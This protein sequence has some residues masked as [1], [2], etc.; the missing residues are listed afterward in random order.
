MK[1]LGMLGGLTPT[2]FLRDY[3]HKQPYLIRQAFPEFIPLFTR[4]ALFSMA[5]REDVESRLIT[6]F[7]RQWKL[8]HGPFET[9]PAPTQKGWT[10]LLQSMNLHD[11]AADALLRQF[12]FIPDARLDDLMISYASDT[13]GVGP[14]FDSYDVF[15]IQAQG[16]RRWRISAQEDLSCRAGMP[17]KILSNFQADQEFLLEPGDMLYLPPQYAHEGTAVGECMT[18]SVGFR[19]PS[20]Q[21]LGESFLQFMADTIDLPG[22]YADPG[23]TATRYPAKIDAA[24][25]SEISTQLNKIRFTAEDIT[26]FVGE[27]FSEPKA[28][29]VF[30]PPAR[31]LSFSK[32]RQQAAQRGFA[33]SRPTIM[34][35]CNNHIFVNGESFLVGKLDKAILSELANFR[36]LDAN[37]FSAATDDVWEAFYEWY[38]N[39]WIRPPQ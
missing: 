18:Y 11:D 3:W 16:Q 39:G 26:I 13:G 4:E 22:R 38:K 33:L 9:V 10:L 34:L 30:D 36:K 15:L 20:Y 6:H 27:S 19:A 7:R 1:K 2:Q 32:F 8:N 5:R 14:H 21:E 25:L 37:S 24:M 31:P 23:L 29:V 12:S 28:S 35:Y 17:L